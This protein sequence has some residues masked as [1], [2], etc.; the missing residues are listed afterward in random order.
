MEL[1]EGETLAER[2]T[3]GPIPPQEALQL[4]I[5]IAEAL[6]AAHEKG[7]IHRDLKP[8][9]I[10]VDAEGQVKV[11]D[12]G[13][14]KAFADEV[15]ESELS[16]SPTLSRDATRAGVILG[17]AAYM[18]P[19]QAK[20]KTVDKRTDIF[21]FGIVLYEILTGKKAFAGEDIS[22]VLASIIKTEPDWKT[23]PRDLDPR[24]A[25]LLRRCLRKDRKKRLRD[26]GDARL[27][28]ED[29]GAATEGSAWADFAGRGYSRRVVGLAGLG[30]LILG[31]L[32]ASAVWWQ[33]GERTG[34]AQV[35]RFWITFPSS[36]RL[37]G[38]R[39]FAVSRDGRRIAYAGLLPDGTRRLFIRELDELDPREIP[40]TDGAGR[41]FFSPD[42]EEVVFHVRGPGGRGG[43]LMRVRLDGG[44]PLEIVPAS[45]VRWAGLDWGP[46]DT[47]VFS[48]GVGGLARVD[49][50]RRPGAAS[51]NRP[52]WSSATEALPRWPPPDGGP[53]KA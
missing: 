38:S 9:N 23:L 41:P 10:K 8:A 40:G 4:S 14:A 28:I 48:T 19:E 32:L 53:I 24:I 42:D 15:P 26:I 17:T 20:G 49:R 36:A 45:A 46:D 12:F 50:P 2:I 6:E 34:D 3:R 22:D 37:A 33:G 16:A 5:Q 31:A 13:L 35:R 44:R 39:S 29:V 52:G 11:L 51:R 1:V 27:E 25:S 7:V 47:I 21:S 30:S 43:S 18:S